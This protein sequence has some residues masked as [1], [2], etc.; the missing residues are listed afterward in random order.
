MRAGLSVCAGLAISLA[1]PIV[2]SVFAQDFPRPDGGWGDRGR[3]RFGRG[4][5]RRGEFSR[6]DFPRGESSREGFRSGFGPPGGFS[7]GSMPSFPGGGFPQRGFYPGGPFP[8]GFPPGG[9]R[10]GGPPSAPPPTGSP[11]TEG[12]QQY[13]QFESDLRH[14]DANRNGS[15]D[16]DEVTGNHKARFEAAMAKAGMPAT[17]PVQIEPIRQR[18]ASM[19]Q[20]KPSPTSSSGPSVQTLTGSVPAVAGFGNGAGG[21]VAGFG[22]PTMASTTA[23]SNRPSPTASTP[24]PTPPASAPPPSVPPVS[25]D[26]GD[27]RAREFAANILKRYDKNGNGVLEKDEWSGMRGDPNEID[28]NK[29]GVITLDEMAERMLAFRRERGGG[30]PPGPP[31]T[32]GSPPTSTASTAGAAGAATGAGK[33]VWK[34]LSPQ[35]R[36]PAGLPDWFRAK[37]VDGDGQVSMKEYSADWSGSAIAG[38]Q[39]YD[40]NNDGLITPEECLT[41]SK[42]AGGESDDRS[43]RR[44]SFRRGPDDR[45]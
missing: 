29:D 8:G 11:A 45:G 42:V 16:P 14:L 34:F 3:E 4:E 43:F 28:R 31:G 27:Q 2:A 26:P 6:G 12:Q 36:L 35:D 38:F 41:G 15:I 21:S 18:L 44:R 24:S 7:P 33:R 19:L 9:F 10:P 5:F 20:A 40:T 39:K 25:G 13:A 22:A 32:S 23:S 37:D 1:L 17:T 30:G